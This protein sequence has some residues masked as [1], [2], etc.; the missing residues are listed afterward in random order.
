MPEFVKALTVARNLRARK[1]G[2]FTA[3]NLNMQAHYRTPVYIVERP[4]RHCGGRSAL[5]AN[6][7]IGDDVIRLSYV[8][9]SVTVRPLIS[10]TPSNL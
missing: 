4:T 2:R 9:A 7:R 3:C 10:M 6:D 1:S 8:V 5:V